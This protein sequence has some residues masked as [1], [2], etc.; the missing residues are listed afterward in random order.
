MQI[1]KTR[2]IALVKQAMEGQEF[3]FKE[4]FTQFGNGL[5]N[6]CIRMT[7]DRMAAEDIVQESFL[8]AFASLQQLKDKASFGSWLRRIAINLCLQE[9]KSKKELFWPFDEVI[10]PGSPDDWVSDIDLPSLHHAIKNLPDGCRQI[11]L[12]YTSESYTHK[13]I[14]VM[15][16]I[17]ESTSKSQYQRAKTLLKKELKRNDG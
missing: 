15:L 17:S 2:L 7:G 12:L 11:F 5:F 4:L 8:K 10:E 16:G 6:V 1:D 3:A 9:I 14:A 13:E